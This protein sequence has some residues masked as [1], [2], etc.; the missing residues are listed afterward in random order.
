MIWARKN[1][2][3]ALVTKEQQ[4]TSHQTVLVKMLFADIV[5]R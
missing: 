1:V 4:P 3:L 5:N 2:T